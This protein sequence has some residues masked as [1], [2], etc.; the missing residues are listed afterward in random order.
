MNKVASV[1]KYDLSYFV[2]LILIVYLWLI[3]LLVGIPVLLHLVASGTE[4]MVIAILNDLSLLTT[5]ALFVNVAL[6]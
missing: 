1:I 6:L 4:G 2:R 5:A 3:G